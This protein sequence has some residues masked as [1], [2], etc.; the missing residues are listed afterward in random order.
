V[1]GVQTCALPIYKKEERTITSCWGLD[2]HGIC[3]VKKSK[4]EEWIER[5]TTLEKVIHYWISN[6]TSKTVEI[7][8]LFYD[9]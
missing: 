8:P 6:R 2:K 5:L 9:S 4:K 1:T 3:V 7:I